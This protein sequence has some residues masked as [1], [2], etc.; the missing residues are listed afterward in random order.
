MGNSRGCVT[1]SGD[2]DVGGLA[3]C[4]VAVAGHATVVGGGGLQMAYSQNMR[5]RRLGLASL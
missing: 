5:E 1:Q 3:G 2:G 4:A